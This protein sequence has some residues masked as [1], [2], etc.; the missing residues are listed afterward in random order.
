[1]AEFTTAQD[2]T[3]AQSIQFN[4]LQDHVPDNTRIPPNRTKTVSQEYHQ[5]TTEQ[6]HSFQDHLHHQ[7]QFITVSQDHHNYVLP[8]EIQSLQDHQQQTL[9][10]QKASLQD[11]YHH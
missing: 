2:N 5:H 3:F 8:I 9:L 1:M 7:N 11:H 10:Y 6:K 4:P